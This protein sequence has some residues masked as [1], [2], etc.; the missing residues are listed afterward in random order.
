MQSLTLPYSTWA[1]AVPAGYKLAVLAVVGIITAPIHSL[2][3]YGVGITIVLALYFSLGLK[4]AM[5]GFR[6]MKPFWFILALVFIYH[7]V[8]GDPFE[9]AA[10]TAKIAFLI[11]LANFVTMT[12]KLS[13]MADAVLKFLTPLRRFGIP[14]DKI[15]LSFALVLRFIPQFFILG[16]MLRDAWRMRSTKGASW[17]LLLPFTLNIIDDS[18]R[19]A[20][21]LRARGGIKS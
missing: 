20:E 8:F 1:N 13:D 14:V 18:E 5:F 9:G 17:R 6:L 10:I 16:M 3:V 4:A 11:L 12:S 21:A 19:V 15:A 2:A 7:L